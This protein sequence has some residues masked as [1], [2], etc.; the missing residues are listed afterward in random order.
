[1]EDWRKRYNLYLLIVM[2]LSVVV[3]VYGCRG[4]IKELCERVE[5]TALEIVDEYELILVNDNCPQNSW[6]VIQEICK[7]NKNVVGIEMSRNFGQ[8]KAITA[9][10]DYSTGD[11]VVVMDC[12]LQDRPEE[13]KTLFNK[14]MEGYDAVFAKRKGRKDSFL[15]VFISKI[16]YKVYSYIS[17]GY[18]DPEVCNFSISSRKV[19][20]AYCSMRELHRAFVIYVK[21]VG[22]KQ[23]NIDIPADARKEGKSSYNMKKRIAMAMEILLS[24][25]DKLLSLTVRF[26]FL[27]SLLSVLSIFILTIR[28]FLMNIQAGWSSIIATISLIG[29]IQ[30]MCTGIV[31]LYIGK[32]YMQVKNRPLYIVKSI[33]NKKEDLDENK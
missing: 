25:S 8:I 14:A 10:L 19:I 11:W 3:P 6:E 13:I 16:F 32:I 7:E 29:G 27:V 33:L 22:F 20:D 5:K 31:G 17:E 2:K 23:I 15:K 24:Q 12:D 26:G 4:A 21:W 18:Y 9:G 1:M 30:I 28:Y